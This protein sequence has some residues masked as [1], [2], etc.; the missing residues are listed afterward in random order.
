SEGVQGATQTGQIT[1]SLTNDN[2]VT[3]VTYTFDGDTT[4]T[5][6]GEGTYT[7]NPETGEIT[8]VPDPSF[9]GTATPVEVTVTGTIT[10]ENGDESTVS[11]TGTYTPTVKAAEITVTNDES[12]GVQGAT[13]TG[14]I[15][16]SL[17]NDERV[18]K[19][20]YTFDGDTTKTVPG[21]GTYT[22]NPETGEIT[23]VPDPSFTGTATPVEVTVTGTITNE[24]GEESTISTTGTYTPSV[25]ATEITA[26]N[27][28]SEGVQGATQTGQI[29]SSLTNDDRVTKVTYTFDGETTKTVP[30]EGTYTINPETGE[31][32]FVP[33]PSFTGTATPVE[34]TVTGTIT[35]EN[36]EES[37]ISTTGTYTPTVKSAEIT[38]TNDASEGVQGATQ[39]GQI[40]SSLT[41]D[42]RVTKVI[43]TFDG[44]TSKTVPGE[45]TYTINPETGEITFVPDPS[46]TGTATPVEV[47]VTGTITNENG[48]ES[49]ISTTGTYTPSVTPTTTS[50]VDGDGN[51]ILPN[52]EGNVPSKDIPGYEIVSST[53]D[54]NGNTVHTYRK[55]TTPVTSFVDGD[56]NPILPN[57]EGNAPSKDIPGYEIVSSTTDENGNTVHT[58]RKVTTPV[59]SFVDGDGNP[60]LPNEEGNVPSKDIPG[61]EIV[62]STTDEN[63]N[64][65]HTYRKVTT[66]ITSF[67]DGDGNPI[68]PNEE[69]NVPSKDIPGYEIVS[70]TTDENGNT[71][72]T[73]RKVTTPVTSFVDGDGNPILPNEEGNVP[74]K[75]IPGYEIVSSTTDENGNTVHTYRKVTTPVTSFV[76]GDGNPL[77]PNEEGNVP[78]KDIPGY[79]IVS[80]TTDENGNTVHTYRK[81][82]TPV[83]S[84]V[85][86]DGNL[87]LP[88]EEGNVPSKDIPG[89]EIVSST[90]DENGNTV[91][92][93]RKVTTPVTSF[94]D[95]DGNPLLPNEEGNVPSKDVPGYEIVS[96]TTDENGNTVHTYRKVVKTTTSFVDGDG[97]PILPNEEGNVPSKDIPGYEIVSSTTDENGNTVHTYRKVTTPVT[98]FV[99]ED[100]NVIS[101]NENGKQPSKVISGYELVGSSTDENGNVVHTYRKVV[102]TTTSFVD[103]DGNPILPNEEG[104]VPS[105]DIPGYEIVSSTTDENGN[106]V[107]TYRKVTT[108]VT[109]FVDEDGNVISPNENGKQPSKDISGYELVGS[110][111]DESGNVVHTYRKVVKTTTSFVDGDG[112]PI[113]PNEEGNVPSKD[114]P[115]YEIISSTTDENGNTVHTYRK[116]TTPVTSFV[117]EDGNVISPNEDGKQPS[118][119]ISG[120]ELVGSSTDEN[121][122]VVHTYRKVVKTTTSFVD[123]D[124]NPIL[125][126]EEGNVPSKDIPGY[127][128]ISSTT[129]ENGNTVHTYRKVT[130][131]VTSFVDEDGNVISPN[132]DGKQPSK[133]ISGYELVGSST[134][135]NGNVVHT[136]RKVVKTTTSFVDGDGN[137]IFPNE[138]GN[139]PSKDIPG[140]E[141][142]SSITD[143]NGNT[144][145]T[146]RKVTTPVT[147]FVDEDGNVISPN[148]DGKQPSK[149]ISGYELVGSSTDENGNV[150]HTYRKVVKTTTSFVDGDGNP[151]LPNE[152]G[153]VPSKDIPGYE[154]IS[155]TTD[156]NG[157][158]V[159]TYR[160]VTTPVTSFVDEDGNVI[161]PN[162][163]GKQPSKAISG[164]ELVGSRTDENGNVIHTYRKVV[165]T[166]TS[167]VDGDGNPILP[168]EEGNVPSKDIPGYE[169]V[170]STTD[171]NGNT[172]HTYRKVVK[173][174]EP[175]V[176]TPSSPKAPTPAKPAEA[177][178]APATKTENRLEV[179]PNTGTENTATAS[180]LGVGMILTALGLAGKRR[181]KE[182]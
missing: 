98:S 174:E 164:Y 91:H 79:E 155:S 53:T 152:E 119:N 90:T 23:F 144:V 128:I 108:P 168:N 52:E 158:T 49:T 30:G 80:S 14:Q 29:T 130:T 70:S 8:F 145:H 60:L 167:F 149:D 73:Y 47:T 143:A 67:V 25:K 133:A 159:H 71:V 82:T 69:G 148:E 105:K 16:S 150:V 161:S 100:G 176:P 1:S 154:I 12:E 10:N 37:T 157:N 111:T 32:T 99:D 68:L 101:P 15:T 45:G 160:K 126:N 85:D 109:S 129:D 21:E 27:D 103:G 19:V 72:H 182:D 6:P 137:P 56:G 50:F 179:L 172:V 64:T 59:T 57:E 18:T 3:K 77:L 166:T 102:K 134:D 132:E 147:S 33:D 121:G 7:I 55:V 110:S 116:V 162:E 106:T 96:S 112:N 36:G 35:N 115:G 151:I 93:Y 146:Y 22:I 81:V 65:V 74:S 97:N 43:Y 92:T 123:G 54:E 153:N 88:N 173:K 62:S 175:S 76:D 28:E 171:A 138:E 131:P 117:D 181:R 40:T 31:I 4:K 104:N 136:Y 89:Y 84:F 139:V 177:K 118:K 140:Y 141:L 58:Y 2:R 5:V 135:E 120:Y 107:H 156:A 163:D 13:Q 122:N 170:S 178:P 86:G 142:V 113:L 95:G 34:V 165:K 51:P 44:E 114:I 24:N 20:T 94:V 63:G 124:G 42:E 61:Y 75:D 46:F 26:T 87:L 9:T 169:I 39:T 78:S 11:T 180:A 38:A 66:P 125:P 48:E 41:N 83:T 17:T 127:E